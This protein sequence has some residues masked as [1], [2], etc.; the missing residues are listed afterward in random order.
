MAR[1]NTG[2][3]A[4]TTGRTGGGVVGR[5]RST[6]LA[7][8]SDEIIVTVAVTPDHA[9]RTFMPAT[10]RSARVSRLPPHGVATT[11]ARVRRQP[12]GCFV[13]TVAPRPA[14]RRPAWAYDTNTRQRHTGA[15][16]ENGR[17]RCAREIY[18]GVVQPAV[19]SLDSSGLTGVPYTGLRRDAGQSAAITRG[20]SS[21]ASTSCTGVGTPSCCPNRTT[22]PVCASNS[23]GRRAMRSRAM[24]V[25][26]SGGKLS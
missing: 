24:L 6:G 10:P 2:C 16:R 12:A 9:R 7:V 15:P 13:D 11:D 26:S 8:N 21:A 23:L 18:A 20:L 19:I 25:R 5:A 17:E 14:G 1:A 4:A 22:A 3:L